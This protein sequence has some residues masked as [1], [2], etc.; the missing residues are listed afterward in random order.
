MESIVHW[1]VDLDTTE[2]LSVN[3]HLPGCGG[4]A[5]GRPLARRLWAVTPVGL[6]GVGKEVPGTR[7]AAPLVGCPGLLLCL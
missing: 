2:R 1:V 5:L 4:P 3:S 6:H 7:E